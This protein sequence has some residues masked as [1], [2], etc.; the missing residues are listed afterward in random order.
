[1]GGIREIV[2]RSDFDKH[3][4]IEKDQLGEDWGDGFFV[5]SE[6]VLIE[7]AADG[8]I[9]R[10]TPL[11]EAFL[12]EKKEIAAETAEP[13]LAKQT[14]Q[15]RQ[16][17]IT[18]REMLVDILATRMFKH[19]D[20]LTPSATTLNPIHDGI[21]TCHEH[22]LGCHLACQRQAGRYKASRGE[23]YEWMRRLVASR[24]EVI[25]KRTG[26]SGWKADAA[27]A[28]LRINRNPVLT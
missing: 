27:N 22:P 7:R 17:G 20:S 14:R 6:P 28:V 16:R 26:N 4:N 1:M 12:Q 10:T 9:A 19:Y 11:S 25:D 8:S 15:L 5:Q 23:V 13:V 21:P 18:E 24:I 3:G 2:D